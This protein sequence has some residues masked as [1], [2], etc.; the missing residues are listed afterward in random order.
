MSVHVKM[1]TY[2]TVIYSSIITEECTS[3]LL[4]YWNV[5]TIDA[6]VKH[7]RFSFTLKLASLRVRLWFT[8]WSVIVALI[9]FETT[10]LGLPLLCHPH[11][12]PA[13]LLSPPTCPP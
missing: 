5:R 13:A 3:H 4:F 6:T 9:S 1:E 7:C 11:I 10:A 2:C 8:T 12:L